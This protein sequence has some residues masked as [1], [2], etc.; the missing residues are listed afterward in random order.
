MPIFSYA[1]SICKT[2]EDHYYHSFALAQQS[3]QH[4]NKGHAMKRII[5][6][7]NPSLYFEQGRGRWIEN[8][9]PEPVYVTSSRQHHA[10]MKKY[11]V[12][13][14]TKDDMLTAKTRRALDARRPS[15]NLQ[16]AFAKAKE[17][18]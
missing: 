13:D 14:A 11:G 15:S 5:A 3:I 6:A 7:I 17:R 2:E 9:G 18:L 4:C 10:L 1:C 12:I 8:L 16:D